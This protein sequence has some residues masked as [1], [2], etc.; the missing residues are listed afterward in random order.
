MLTSFYQQK[1]PSKVAEVDKLL[2]KYQGKEEQMFRNLAKK[3][4]LDP[5]VF[6]LPSA[7]P[8]GA[9]GSPPA[10]GPTSFGQAST[11]GGGA[12]PFGQSAGF[13][14]SKG[15]GGVS[16]GQTFGSGISS[17]AGGSTFGS[18]A[19]SSNPSPFGASTG[20]FG[21]PAPAFNAS[22]PMGFGGGSPFGAPR[23]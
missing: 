11:L 10:P 19:Q 14:Q 2:A 22:S 16:S 8:T 12:S 5:S 9:F 6:G 20:G 23:R 13:G 18:L 21:S 7:P 3:Y 1:N 15:F 4:M 17:G